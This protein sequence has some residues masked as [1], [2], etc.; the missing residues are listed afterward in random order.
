MKKFL[1]AAIVVMMVS[2]LILGGCTPSTPPASKPPATTT[3]TT[4]ATHPEVKLEIWGGPFGGTPYVTGF[5][6]MDTLNKTHPWLHGSIIES[7]GGWDNAL[8]SDKDKAK[9]PY[10]L[11]APSDYGIIRGTMDPVAKTWTDGGRVAGKPGDRLVLCTAAVTAQLVVTFDPN[12]K[13]GKD[14]AGKKMAGWTRGSGAYTTLAQ[15]FAE[16][17]ITE[18]DLKTY[19]GMELKAKNDALSDGLVDAIHLSEPFVPDKPTM[20]SAS[21]SE[22]LTNPKTLYYIPVT[23]AEA[24]VGEAIYKANKEY[25]T[26]RMDIPAGHY[27]KNWPA[28]GANMVFQTAWV[29][30]EMPEEIQYEL[31]KALIEKSADIAGHGGAAISMIPSVLVGGMPITS[32]SEMAPGALKYYKESGVWAKYTPPFLKK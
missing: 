26:P 2:A 22:L 5:A 24:A 4:P 6:L 28:G 12:I 18:K 29:Y 16:W 3:P 21:L 27:S 11:N 14:L 23:K 1:V 25:F 8:N 32:E 19:D 7:K 10:V 31:A 17:G 20:M 13:A 9:I 15:M 30:K